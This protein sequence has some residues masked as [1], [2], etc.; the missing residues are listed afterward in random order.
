MSNAAKK[1]TDDLM[2][3][4]TQK[5]TD[6]QDNIDTNT[7]SMI[8]VNLRE[9]WDGLLKKSGKSKSDIINGADISYI[10][11]YE[12][13]QGKKNP[14]KDKIVRLSLAMELT[15]AE[16]QQ[17]LRFCNHAALYPR[18]KRDSILIYAVEN[19]LSVYQTQTLLRQAG[20]EELK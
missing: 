8:E 6:L 18:L 11:F 2:A 3:E 1:S 20:E 4:L 13:L 10:Y 9:F 15:V 19:R 16:C 5:N 7:S 14:T 17:A 12:I